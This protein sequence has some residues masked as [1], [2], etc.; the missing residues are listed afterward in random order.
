[1]AKAETQERN[2]DRASVMDTIVLGLILNRLRAQAADP[3]NSILLFA[4]ELTL[5][6]DRREIVSTS[7]RP[8]CSSSR[9]T[10]A[11]IAPGGLRIT[12]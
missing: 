1:M 5:Q 9:R 8:W 10:R 12:G 7:S 2:G 6:M 3:F 4:L 11:L